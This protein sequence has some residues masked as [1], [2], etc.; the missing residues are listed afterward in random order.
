MPFRLLKHSRENMPD[1]AE[2][3]YSTVQKFWRKRQQRIVRK[4][5]LE[6]TSPQKARIIL[7]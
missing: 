5:T 6:K 2:F 3:F 1:V 4:A 7:D